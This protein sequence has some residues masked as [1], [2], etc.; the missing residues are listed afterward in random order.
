MTEYLGRNLKDLFKSRRRLIIEEA[1]RILA[2]YR[3][4]RADGNGG[5]SHYELLLS[6]NKACRDFRP[7]HKNNDISKLKYKPPRK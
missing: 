7:F 5:I 2:D 3:K 4:L 6:L 1:Y